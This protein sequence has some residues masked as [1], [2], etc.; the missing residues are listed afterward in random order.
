VSLERVKRFNSWISIWCVLALFGVCRAQEKIA[1]SELLDLKT[2]TRALQE[3]ALR[4]DRLAA[5]IYEWRDLAKFSKE[6]EDIGVLMSADRREKKKRYV[7]TWRKGSRL[8]AELVSG[9]IPSKESLDRLFP[10][11]GP[12]ELILPK[13]LGFAV[14]EEDGSSVPLEGAPSS[15]LK[16]FVLDLNGDGEIEVM[17]AA[18]FGSARYVMVRLLTGPQPLFAVAYEWGD[19]KARGKPWGYAIRKDEDGSYDILFGQRGRDTIAPEV[20]F[21]WEARGKTWTCESPGD[22]LRVL[23]LKNVWNEIIKLGGRGSGGQTMP[24]I[25]GLRFNDLASLRHRTTW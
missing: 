3:F 11:L 9:E 8:D 12:A 20:V 24:A 4:T 13:E 21:R 25:G 2:R 16:G 15:E 10:P 6:H 23:G 18:E 17:E 5:E 14:F 19:L 7:V 22:H 1:I